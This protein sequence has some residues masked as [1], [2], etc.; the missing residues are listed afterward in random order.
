[1]RTF[2]VTAAAF[3]WALLA[4]IVA[5]PDAAYATT[6][7]AYSATIKN[8]AGVVLKNATVRVTGAGGVLSTIYSDAGI[9]PLANP[10]TTNS[11]GVLS[12]YAIAGNYRIVAGGDGSTVLQV[13]LPYVSPVLAAMTGACTGPDVVVV[14]NALGVGV[15]TATSG[16]G[17]NSFETMNAPSG[18][19]PVADSA[20]D[21]LNITCAGGL[22]CTGTAGTDTLDFTIS[23]AFPANTTSTASNF[24]AA[25]NSTTGAFTKAQPAFSDLTGAATDSQVPDTITID[26]AT[27]ATSCTQALTGDSATSFFGAGTLE[28]NRGGTGVATLTN[29]GVVLG[30]GTSLVAVTAA[31]TSGQPFLSGGASADPAFGT[32][33]SAG[34]TDGTIVNADINASAAIALSKLATATAS[35]CAR[36]DSGGVLVPASGDCASGDTDTTLATPVST[37]NGGLGASNSA[38]TGVPV[39]AAGT[40]TVTTPTGSGAPVLATSPTLV[41]PVLG[42]AAATS[43]GLPAGTLA[44]MALQIVQAGTGLWQPATN[45]LGIGA[46]GIEVARFNTITSG[47]NYLTITPGIT[48]TTNHVLLQPGGSD[49]NASIGISTKGN[50]GGVR[51]YFGMTSVDLFQMDGNGLTSLRQGTTGTTGGTLISAGSPAVDSTHP[52]YS[53]TGDT[54]TGPGWASANTPVT[55]AGGVPVISSTSAGVTSFNTAATA[56]SKGFFTYGGTCIV[57]TNQT[58][59]STTPQTAACYRTTSGSV[60]IALTASHW[61]TGKCELFLSDSVAVDGAVMDFDSSTATA[62]T[63]R[64]QITAFDTAL[65]LSTQTTALATDAAATTFTGAGAF[66]VHFTFQVNAAGTFQPRFFQSTHSTG[67]LTLGAGSHCTLVDATP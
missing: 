64:A 59:A 47:V 24:F 35:K 57:A 32:V 7:Y 37:A 19:D 29:H 34:I 28:V 27:L 25:Y 16:G 48:A 18:T 42:A 56:D 36:F 43:I 3:V 14:Y 15:C 41:T 58:N 6:Y 12:F 26:L 20:T 9:T 11:S 51:I 22:T 62:T 50:S 17:G 45:T 1:M 60:A 55:I 66:E 31:G 44:A 8:H 2:K 30:Q 10:T 4:V 53:Y 67:T 52:G 40:A 46:N 54:D 65:N 63:F 21:T 49:S 5:M 23:S 61:Y 33:A 39:F 13:T 38:A